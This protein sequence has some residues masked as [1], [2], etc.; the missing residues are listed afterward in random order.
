[1]EQNIKVGHPFYFPTQVVLLDDDPDFLDGI[2][3]M[4]NKSL[5]Y[6][7]F[8]SAAQALEYVNRAHQHVEFLQ[9]SY[10][11]Y[12]TGPMESD[13]LSHI[14]I[15]KLH[16]E[17]LNGL[18][19]QTTST[20]IVDYSMPEMNGLEFLMA[21]KNP[22][23]KKVLL[24]GQADMEIA[25]NAFN[26]QIIDQFI[27]KHD[28]KLR[29]KLNS[30]IE[31][32]QDQYFRSSFKLITDPII[33]N[34]LDAFLVDAEFQNFF[35]DLRQKLDCAEYYMIDF[36]HSGFLMISST[37]K[38]H[39]L[40]IHTEASLAE[41]HKS[42][43]KMNAPKELADQVMTGSLIPG[44]N[45][46]EDGLNTSHENIKNWQEAYY[47]GIRIDSPKKFYAT[48]ISDKLLPSIHEKDIIPYNDF[49]ET[50]SLINEIVH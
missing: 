3:L 16:H 8:Q 29:E 44:F 47:P 21:I 7:L 36:P 34:N 14:D 18:R 28:P 37:G 13:S 46:L 40:L 20:V 38:R 43:V 45:T 31:N 30:T 49:I 1:M 42:L 41:H 32:F 11:N 23:I 6:K 27:D 25:I 4:L 10:T 22:F 15:G 33:A 50:N 19:F 48:I 35:D 26:K 2:S 17:V 39:C 12:K 5:S 9:R 24:T